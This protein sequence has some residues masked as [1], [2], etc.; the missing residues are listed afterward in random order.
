MLTTLLIMINK[1]ITK[2]CK[3]LNKNGSVFPASIVLPM[4][5]KLLTKLKYP[6]YVIGITGSSG[7]GTATTL[8]AQTLE[9]NGLKVVWNSSGSNVENGIATLLLNNTNM[10]SHKIDGDAL[11]LELDEAYLKETFKKP[12]LTHLIVTNVTRDQPARN[13]EPEIILNK[14]ESALDNNIHLILN[15]DDPLVN[16]LGEGR[17]KV[18][19]Y[20][21]DKNKFGLKSSLSNN[22]DAAY[23]PLCKK[24]LEYDY[25]HYGH[26]GNYKCSKCKYRRK[27]G[28]EATNIDLK[29]GSITINKDKLELNNNAFYTIYSY[30]A[31]YAL[32][33]ELGLKKINTLKHKK[34]N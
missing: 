2:I 17:K 13:T 32:V 29:K 15:A 24:K 34:E 12:I 28:Y 7:K 5:R 31:T 9:E 8:V 18:T 14:I 33:K 4:D 26:L 30:L 19:Y 22:L 21:I 10:F 1:L 6:K 27:I 23:C 25:Y 3:I 11:V 20:G 16:R